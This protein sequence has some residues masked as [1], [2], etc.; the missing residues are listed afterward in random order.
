MDC[1]LNRLF[2]FKNNIFLSET[3]IQMNPT[4]NKSFAQKRKTHEVS[5]DPPRSI[6]ESD[7]E[8]SCKKGENEQR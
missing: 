2:W 7:D 5:E 4:G 6:L 1:K 8:G 3:F